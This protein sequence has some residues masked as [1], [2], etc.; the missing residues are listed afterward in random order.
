[1]ILI[2]LAGLFVYTFRQ[3]HYRLWRLGKEEDCSDRIPERLKTFLSVVFGH[4]RFWKEGYPGTMHFLIFWGTLFVFL[5]K[6]IRIFSLLTGLT[7]PPQGIYLFASSISEIGG[8]IILLGGVMAVVRRFV[9]KPSRL[10]SKPDD[11]LKYLWVF[12]IL[13]TG[14]LV[15][16]YRLALT[17][18]SLPTDSFLWAP[19][20][21]ILSR[22]M[23]ILPSE[24]VKRTPR[25]APGPDPRH[26]RD[27]FLWLYCCEP[28]LARAHLPFRPQCFLS[29]PETEGSRAADPQFRRGGNLRRLGDQGVYLETAAR[30]RGLHPMR[31]MSGQLSG[32][33]E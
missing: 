6:G 9:V 23:L 10:D 4:A 16:G 27:P 22:F 26:P 13:L 3:Q 5:G 33:S 30:S 19:I 11:H 2:G 14:Y 25:L 18:G 7:V 20:S 8:A 17:G 15:K 24:R 29:I 12:V 28:F 31:E 21:S 32:S 1:M